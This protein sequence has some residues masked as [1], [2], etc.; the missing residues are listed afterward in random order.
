M[1]AEA[2]LGEDED[3]GEGEAEAGEVSADEAGAGIEADLVEEGDFHLCRV[4]VPM[5]FRLEEMH[6]NL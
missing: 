2:L 4:R 6:Q 5:R 1:E 3:G